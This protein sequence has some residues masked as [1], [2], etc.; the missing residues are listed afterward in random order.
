V[1]Y[2]IFVKDEHSLKNKKIHIYL[3]FI[4]TQY[5]C[6]YALVEHIDY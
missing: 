2:L 5:L 1:L 4:D 6:K 3:Y